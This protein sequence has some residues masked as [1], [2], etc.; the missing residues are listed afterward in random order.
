MPTNVFES[1]S[2]HI[3]CSL[4]VPDALAYCKIRKLIYQ[5]KSVVFVA[6]MLGDGMI[7]QLCRQYVLGFTYSDNVVECFLIALKKW[8]SMA[9]YIQNR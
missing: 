8:K 5:F 6:P 7:N 1:T 9:E 4:S 2:Q 3:S